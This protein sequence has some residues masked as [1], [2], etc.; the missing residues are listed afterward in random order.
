S[1]KSGKFH[2]IDDLPVPLQPEQDF[3]SARRA[4]C[5]RIFLRS[6]L[7]VLV[8]LPSK[9]HIS[10]YEK[11]DLPRICRHLFIFIGNKAFGSSVLICHYLSTSA[12]SSF[13]IRLGSFTVK[14]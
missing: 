3:L 2:F 14:V 5:F 9:V 12:S 8:D 7:K 10:V 11:R 13:S 1:L 4:C 6:I